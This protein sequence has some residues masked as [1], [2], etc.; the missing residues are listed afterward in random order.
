VGE[1]EVVFIPHWRMAS[2]LAAPIDFIGCDDHLIGQLCW[3]VGIKELATIATS[4]GTL[5]QFRG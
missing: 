2:A 1:A 3:W 4:H 5:L